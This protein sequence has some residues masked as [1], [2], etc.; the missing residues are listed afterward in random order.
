MRTKSLITAT[1]LEACSEGV[2]IPNVINAVNLDRNIA[3]SYF[4]SLARS[5]LIESADGIIYMTTD[6]GIEVLGQLWVI[7]DFLNRHG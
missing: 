2:S 4:D 1:I 5:G 3:E 6:K 7:Q